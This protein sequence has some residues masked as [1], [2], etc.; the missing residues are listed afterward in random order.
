MPHHKSDKKETPNTEASKTETQIK[1]VA[2]TIISYINIDSGQRNKQHTNIY[3]GDL[4]NLP[5]YPLNF[6]N[7]SS[8]VTINF[9][10]HQLDIDDQI[11]LNNVISK[12]IILQNV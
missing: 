8:V 9:P 5:P 4:V 2:S 12:N 3:T 10:N 7:G 6:T 11:I 1:P